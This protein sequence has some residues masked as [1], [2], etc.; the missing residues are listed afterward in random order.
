MSYLRII[1]VEF[2]CLVTIASHAQS[3]D[4]RIA[5]L[6][7]K[8]VSLS[9]LARKG[10][11]NISFYTI[12]ETT[13]TATKPSGKNRSKDRKRVVKAAKAL[14]VPEPKTYMAANSGEKYDPNEVLER[15]FSISMWVMPFASSVEKSGY[16]LYPGTGSNMLEQS[17]WGITVSKEYVRVYETYKTENLILQYRHHETKDF[18]IVLVC[19]DRIPYLYINGNLVAHG[20]ASL[21]SPHPS[22]LTDSSC[23]K[24]LRLIGKKTDIHLFPQAL[25]EGEIAGLYRQEYAALHH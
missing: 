9:S 19:K 20:E 14:I 10:S 16:L 1:V 13:V 22:V 25:T 5:P 2:L 15:G 3:Y 24:N 18:F 12:K 6:E 4:Y 7:R 21:Y 23:P 8:L 17:Y 11:S